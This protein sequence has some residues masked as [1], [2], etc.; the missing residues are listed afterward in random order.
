[1]LYNVRSATSHTK[2]N[3]NV[4]RLLLS[5]KFAETILLPGSIK[6]MVVVHEYGIQ[7][8]NAAWRVVEKR[9]PAT[10]CLPIA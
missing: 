2:V 7:V 10:Q 3:T 4:C 5:D 8:S 1:M 9:C 6:N